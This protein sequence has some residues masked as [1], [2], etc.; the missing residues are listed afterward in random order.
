MGKWFDPF[1]KLIINWLCPPNGV[2]G[3]FGFDWVRFDQ[4]SKLHFSLQLV[5]F[6][7]VINI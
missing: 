3:K 7:N 5:V 4:V 6:I 1:D 2:A